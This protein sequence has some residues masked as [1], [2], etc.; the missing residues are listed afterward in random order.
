MPIVPLQLSPDQLQFMK[1]HAMRTYPDECCG[2]LLGTLSGEDK[3][4]VDIRAVDN[5][6]NQEVAHE[7]KAES[8]LTKT[9][10]YWISTEDML[11]VMREARGRNLDVIGIYHSHPDHPACPSECDRQLA[12]P[13]YS[14][15]ILSVIQ[16]QARECYSWQLD[17]THQ[18]QPESLVLV[19]SMLH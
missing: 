5:C 15:I 18:F 17:E 1:T 8:S 12:W 9:R 10:R 3:K 14:Y 7:L 11:F 16:G 2:L 4:L 13:Q 19:E 6:W